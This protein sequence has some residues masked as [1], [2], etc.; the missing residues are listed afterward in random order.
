MTRDG[1]TITDHVCRECFGRVLEHSTGD[2]V[3]MAYRCSNCG[4]ERE[5]A[6]IE[7]FCCC[8][9][10]LKTGRDAGIRCTPTTGMTLPFPAEIVAR[11]SATGA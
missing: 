4:C 7:A 8:G 6:R 5:A 2:P 9:L 3:V 11:H 1:W 10:H